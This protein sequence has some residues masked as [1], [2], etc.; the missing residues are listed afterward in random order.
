[1]T[2]AGVSLHLRVSFRRRQLS[3]PSLVVVSRYASR[4]VSRYLLSKQWVSL[5]REIAL[6]FPLT[7]SIQAEFNIRAVISVYQQSSVRRPRLGVG[8]GRIR[9]S[10]YSQYESI[11]M[12]SKQKKIFFSS[13]HHSPHICLTW[14][15]SNP[16]LNF[17]RSEANALRSEV[18]HRVSPE[19]VERVQV[20]RA[21]IGVLYLFFPKH[22]GAYRLLFFS[23]RLPSFRLIP[24]YF[25]SLHLILD[26]T[27][28]SRL[29]PSF[30]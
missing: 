9:S 26:A 19:L 18:T 13:R 7:A 16:P 30:F 1:M 14:Y 24:L 17:S 12:T 20:T 23:L 8:I 6:K 10:Y 11:V 28:V 29:I 22:E 5:T 2:P 15:A 21:S 25:T 3:F 4:R 27:S